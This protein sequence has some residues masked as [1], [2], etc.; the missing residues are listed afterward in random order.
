MDDKGLVTNTNVEIVHFELHLI[1][2][3]GGQVF[4]EDGHLLT[5]E[6]KTALQGVAPGEEIYFEDIQGVTA[7]GEVVRLNPL[8]YTL[9]N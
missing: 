4:E 1:N 5:G 8:R 2:G 9:L 7:N 6:M 3:R